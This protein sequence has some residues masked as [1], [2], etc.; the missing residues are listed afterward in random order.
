LR[1]VQNAGELSLNVPARHLIEKAPCTSTDEGQ[2]L[3]RDDGHVARAMLAVH[4]I[5]Y[6]QAFVERGREIS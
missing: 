5:L 6:A 3:R 1:I 2:D 4:T